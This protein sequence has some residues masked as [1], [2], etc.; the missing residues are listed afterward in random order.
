MALATAE[1]WT[2][3]LCDI[4]DEIDVNGD[5][6]LEWDEFTMYCIEDAM[7]ATRREGATVPNVQVPPPLLLLYPLSFTPTTHTLTRACPHPVLP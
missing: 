6:N 1:E 5:G 7:A 4:F 2:V 3:K